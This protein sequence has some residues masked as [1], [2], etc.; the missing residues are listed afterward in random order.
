MNIHHVS[1][2]L[3]HIKVFDLSCV[4]DNKCRHGRSVST[5]PVLMI[6]LKNS[7]HWHFG[8]Q[9]HMQQTNAMLTTTAQFGW[10]S[11]NRCD[12]ASL[13]SVHTLVVLTFR[14]KII[15]AVHIDSKVCGR[16]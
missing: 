9:K 2:L 11:N 13:T 16:P 14:N 15:I 7:N 10:Y 3:I 6:P 12:S 1:Q 8:Q 5:A 4:G